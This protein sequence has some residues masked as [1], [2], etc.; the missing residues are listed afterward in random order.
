MK[1]NK[2]TLATVAFGLAASASAADNAPNVHIASTNVREFG[3]WDA[4]RAENAYLDDQIQNAK[5]KKE[6]QGLSTDTSSLIGPS[7]GAATATPQRPLQVQMV[8]GLAGQL[9]AL[10][11]LPVGGSVSVRVGSVI[12]GMGTVKS[13]SINEVLVVLEKSRQIQPIPFASDNVC[14]PNNGLQTTGAAGGAIPMSPFGA[15]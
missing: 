4:I 5:K 15:R 1:F 6:L 2:L 8:S 9:R 12:P 7:V 14:A 11:C 3:D 10:L 13:I